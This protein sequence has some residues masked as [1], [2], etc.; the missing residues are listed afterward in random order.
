M[1]YQSISITTI[2]NLT[3]PQCIDVSKQ[4]KEA[5]KEVNKNKG[6]LVYTTC[7]K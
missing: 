3:Q 5:M 1:S 7:V 2:N 6:L 4:Y